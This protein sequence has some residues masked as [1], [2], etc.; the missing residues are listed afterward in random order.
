MGL[1]IKAAI[2]P[3]LFWVKVGVLIALAA[4][5]F[6]AGW[7]VNG[8]RWEAK[9]SAQVKALQDQVERDRADYLLKLAKV[10]AESQVDSAKLDML[11]TQKDA[12]LAT[13]NGLK[14]TR[15]V[16]VKPDAQGNCVADV[17][18]P[19]F[20]MRWNEVVASAAATAAAD[21]GE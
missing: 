16:T 12:L 3:Y 21:S 4:V 13:L 20:R 2:A 19:D 14:L 9:E 7:A 6:W 1:P 15:T 17:I 5:L 18:A 11:E 8:W 10:Q